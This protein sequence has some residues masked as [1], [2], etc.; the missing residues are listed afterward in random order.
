MERDDR[1]IEIFTP[2]G[3]AF[4]LTKRILFQPFDLKKWF[5][6]GFAAF[7]AGLADGTRFGGG[8]F[9]SPSG[10]WKD[11][12]NSE[13]FSALSDQVMSWLFTGVMAAVVVGVL[14]MIFLFMWLGSRG[15]FIFIDC[16][17]HDRGAI[18][19]PWREYKRDANS[20]FLFSLVAMVA[21]LLFFALS[22]LPFFLLWWTERL[23]DIGWP[24]FVYGGVVVLLSLLLSLAYVVVAWFMVPVMYRQ[25]CRALAAFKKVIKL[26][27]S[28]PGPFVLYALFMIV[29]IVGGTLLSCLITC[30]TC[31]LAA[32]PYFGTVILLPLYTFYYAF[33][34]LFLRQF[35]SEFDAWGNIVPAELPESD[36]SLPPPEPP[37]FQEPPPLPA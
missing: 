37:P 30:L 6:I 5:V 34:L 24:L 4:E 25:R 27:A 10:N 8:N 36:I 1:K 12:G 26:I 33:T 23:E 20:F 16:I 17:V 3:D 35:G 14:V 13:R 22:A 31:C 21:W 19:A 18:E 7:L 9:P 32:I 29:L 2:F 11:G 15:R 28:Y